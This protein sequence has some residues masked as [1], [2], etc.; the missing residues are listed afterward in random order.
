MEKVNPIEFIK[1]LRSGE[2]PVC[3][4]CGE[5]KVSTEYDPQTS[6]YFCCSKC[7]L[8]VNID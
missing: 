4:Q 2:T 1:S 7:D 8:I 6:H 3:P 5:G